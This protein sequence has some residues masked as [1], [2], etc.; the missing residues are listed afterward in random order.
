M[1]V[2]SLISDTRTFQ[3]LVAAFVI[4]IQSMSDETMVLRFDECD[5]ERMAAADVVHRIVLD[6]SCSFT[7]APHLQLKRGFEKK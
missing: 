4:A 3:K 1:S 7:I 2:G 5:D 6:N